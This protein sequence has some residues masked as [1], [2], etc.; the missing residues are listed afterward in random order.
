M[1]KRATLW[2]PMHSTNLPSDHD[3]NYFILRK[4]FD[5]LKGSTVFNTLDLFQGYRK[6]EM[7]ETYTQEATFLTQSGPF[8]FE[9]MLFG[10][11]NAHSTFQSMMN[12]IYRGFLFARAYLEYV[13]IHSSFLEEDLDHLEVIVGHIRQHQLKL[14]VENST[15][16]SESIEL[17]G[18]VVSRDGKKRNQRR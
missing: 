17:L 4:K 16:C 12:Y 3:G 8:S 18:H 1:V 9:Y 14:R 6:T 10:L 15:F 13:I 5:E 2:I 11:I 7:S